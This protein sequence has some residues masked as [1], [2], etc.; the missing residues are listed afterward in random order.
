[1]KLESPQPAPQAPGRSKLIG[2]T[3]WS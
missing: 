3:P 2:K 1:M